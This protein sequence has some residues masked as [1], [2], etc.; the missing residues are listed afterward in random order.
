MKILFV[1]PNKDNFGFK[2]IGVALL[3]AIARERGWKTYLYDTTD[4]DLD[5]MTST[6]AA[7]SVK[8]FKSIDM[9][10][11]GWVK[12]KRDLAS[13]FTAS[14]KE[15]GPDVICVSAL[16]D[17]R[18]IAKELTAIAKR[19]NP[20]VPVI[21]GN[22]FATLNPEATL[23]EYGADFVCLLEGIEAFPEFV[24]ALDRG[25]DPYSIRNV[26]GKRDGEVVKTPIRPLLR[27]LDS[28]PYLDWSIF[29]KMGHFYKAFDGKAYKAGDHMSNW[30]CPYHC[31]YCINHVLH[32]MYDGKYKMRRYSVERY[33]QELKNLK[34]TYNLEFFKFHDED[35]LMRPK[36][37]MR[38]FSERYKE[39]INLPFVI[40][41]NP[42][43]VTMEN[44]RLLK[45]MNCVSVSLAIETGDMVMREEVLKR[46]DSEEH[47][48]NSF[49]ILNDLD[50][51]TSSF[52]MLGLPYETRETFMKSV[53]IVRRANVRQPMA[54]F[55]FPFEQTELRQIA[56][57]EGFY[58]GNDE[59]V[60]MTDKPALTFKDMTQDELINMKSVFVLYCK[61]PKVFFPY[62]RRAEGTDELGMRIRR[63]L[64]DLYDDMVFAHEGWYRDQDGKESRHLETLRSLCS[65]CTAA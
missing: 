18:L 8:L 43:S 22:K 34:D 38:E 4:A 21:W 62:I 49:N 35:F 9:E 13:H 23:F 55:F 14:L 29:T 32:K 30:G 11:Y 46:V 59:G 50:I 58:D 26:W 5:F 64:Y 63:Y 36:Q 61:L 10:P 27:D 42:K 52:F 7:T 60:Y 28:L 65:D 37:H 41:T 40:E 31:T 1:W 33:I 39:D 19:W 25:K 47:I 12:E 2:P 6:T 48:I 15:V 20:D 53:D 56:I 51:R 57:D 3:S 54:T 16:S 44:G 17:E 45:E 24:E